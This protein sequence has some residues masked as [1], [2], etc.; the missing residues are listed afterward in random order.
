MKD[1][2]IAKKVDKEVKNI[3]FSLDDLKAEG[4]SLYILAK[5]IILFNYY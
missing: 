4:I 1:I 2:L 5:R 3:E